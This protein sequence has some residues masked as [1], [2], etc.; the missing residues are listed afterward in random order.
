M[1]RLAVTK[2]CVGGEA[3]TGFERI[4]F[5]LLFLRFYPED[6]GRIFFRI[7]AIDLPNNMATHPTRP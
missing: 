3:P 1:L 2:F 6:E 5:R 4:Y 7:V